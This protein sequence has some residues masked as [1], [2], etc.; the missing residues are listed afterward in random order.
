MGQERVHKRYSPSQAD[1][2]FECTGSRTLLDRVP[3]RQ[4]GPYAK[5]G[6]DAHKVFEAAIRYRVSDARV[7]HEEY[8][9]ELMFDILDDGTNDFYSAVQSAIDYVL[10]LLATHPDALVWI[11]EYVEPPTPSAPGEGGGFAD[12]IVWVPSTRTLYVIDYKHGVGVVKRAKTSRQALQYAGGVLFEDN[13]RVDPNIVEAVVCVILQ[14]RTFHPDGGEREYVFPVFE[15]WDYL[16]ELDE[17]IAESEEGFGTL[18]PG[19]LQCQFCDA[20][21]LCPARE[22][23][24]LD[25]AVPGT[26][27]IEQFSQADLPVPSSLD[28]HRL[29]LIRYHADA[30]RKWLSDVDKHCE[31]LS[32]AGHVVPGAKL[33]EAQAKRKYYGQEHDT[34]RKL[35]AMLGER[36]AEAAMDEYAKLMARYP[37]LKRVFRQSIIPITEAEKAVTNAY[38][39][40]VGKG[41]KKKAAE[42]AK[43][44]FAFLTLKQSSG[45]LVLVDEDDPRP[46]VNKARSTFAQ[47]TGALAPPQE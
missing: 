35:A 30:L 23:L 36:N 20:R 10:G 27:T 41:R 9:P 45:N 22:A 28:L 16:Q 38:K 39:Q 47:I 25:V 6:D 46:A 21:T 7:A 4:S 29:A 40:R 32:R 24:G 12:C 42:E 37:V 33:V 31:E 13:A 8:V 5:E 44:A 18:N 43:Q 19:E 3:A 26:E 2:T 11:E 17:K 1:R 15:V 34:A 14:P